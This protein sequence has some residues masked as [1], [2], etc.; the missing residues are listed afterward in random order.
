M[1]NSYH[2]KFG[3]FDAMTFVAATALAASATRHWWAS[4]FDSFRPGGDA[5][6]ENFVNLMYRVRYLLYSA[7]YFTAS[8]S[9]ACLTLGLRQPRMS[10]RFV[11]GQPGMVACLTTAVILGLRLFTVAISFVFRYLYDVN[12]TISQILDIMDEPPQIPSEIGCAIAA[13]WVIQRASGGW[14]PEAYWIDRLGRALGFLWIANI[15]SP[16]SRI[17]R[18]LNL[19]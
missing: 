7:S 14:R 3:I 19:N 5:Y 11:L 8:W 15:P 17:E 18:M 2:R 1:S 12:L 9:L 4:Y 16:L 6:Q 10:F 13:A